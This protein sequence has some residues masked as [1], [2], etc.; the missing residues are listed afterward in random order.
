[1]KRMLLLLAAAV[2]FLNT[3][4]VPTV[5]HADGGSLGGGCSGPS[6]PASRSTVL[7]RKLRKTNREATT[8]PAGKAAL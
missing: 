1:M 6:S 5:A 7:D 4:V 2:L 3:M 8:L